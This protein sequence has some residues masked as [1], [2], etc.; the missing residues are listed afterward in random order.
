MHIGDSATAAGF[1]IST[2]LPVAYVPVL[3]AGIDSVGRL[4]LFLGLLAVHALA[5]VVGHDY[6]KSRPQ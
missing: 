1:W 5:L 3:V 4:S 6:P 2:L